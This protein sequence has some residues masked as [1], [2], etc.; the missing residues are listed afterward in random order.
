MASVYESLWVVLYLLSR[1]LKDLCRISV[2]ESGSSNVLSKFKKNG[3]VDILLDCSHWITLNFRCYIL[4]AKKN[5]YWS[6][7]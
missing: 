3:L 5:K 4:S 1:A 2:S 6:H 7:V